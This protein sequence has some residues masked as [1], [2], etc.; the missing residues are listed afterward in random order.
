MVEEGTLQGDPSRDVD[1]CAESLAS[2][3]LK[4]SP[5]LATMIHFVGNHVASQCTLIPGVSIIDALVQHPRKTMNLPM[6][7]SRASAM[8]DINFE[9][10]Q[11][12]FTMLPRS[13]M[14]SRGKRYR[15]H[16]RKKSMALSI[17]STILVHIY[18]I[19]TSQN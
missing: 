5:L 4:S 8:I 18:I 7:S 19:Y 17:L 2:A 14:H 9:P 11:R 15:W 12:F 10:R 1:P 3:L 16:K 13:A 6:A